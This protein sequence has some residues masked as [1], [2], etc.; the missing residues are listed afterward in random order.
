MFHGGK[1][2][3]L[4]HTEIPE[5]MKRDNLTK[6]SLDTEYVSGKYVIM[7]AFYSGPG[8]TFVSLYGSSLQ[9]SPV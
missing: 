3:A 7:H 5:P 1:K 4:Q 2:T 8:E 6:T 9:L